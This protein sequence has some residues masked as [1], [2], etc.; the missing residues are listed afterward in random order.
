MLVCVLCIAL[1]RLYGLVTLVTVDS[2]HVVS[3]G[4]VYDQHP[5]T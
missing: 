5:A 3:A 4:L 2:G 1:L